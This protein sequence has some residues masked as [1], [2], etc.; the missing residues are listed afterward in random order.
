MKKLILF[1]LCFLACA[2]LVGANPQYTS[3][4]GS[5]YQFGVD[6]SPRGAWSSTIG[7]QIGGN[8]N[9]YPNIMINNSL[10]NML[11]PLAMNPLKST[12][13]RADEIYMFNSY[14]INVYDSNFV[15]VCSYALSAWNGTV[16]PVDVSDYNSYL[17][18][19]LSKTGADWNLNILNRSTSCFTL[20]KS[21]NV[22]DNANYTGSVLGGKNG[23]AYIY[24]VS[25]NVTKVNIKT[26]AETI[27]PF[28]SSGM[29]RCANP[30]YE[31]RSEAVSDDLNGDGYDDL[32]LIG[33]S[34]ASVY[35]IGILNT[36]TGS[37][38]TQITSSSSSFN[39]CTAF[40]AQIGTSS[41]YI[42]AQRIPASTQTDLRVYDFGGN[43]IYSDNDVADVPAAVGDFDLDGNNEL[44]FMDK[45]TGLQMHV[46]DNSFAEKY[47]LTNVI[48]SSSITPTNCPLA[49]Y[50][51]G[52]GY[53]EILSN[54][55]IQLVNSTL[56]LH[57]SSN[58][59]LISTIRGSPLNTPNDTLSIPSSWSGMNYAFPVAIQSSTFKDILL[60]GTNLQPSTAILSSTYGSVC[61]NGICETGETSVTCPED[62]APTT[63]GAAIISR[64]STNPCYT[65]TWLVNTTAQITAAATDQ[66][67]ANVNIYAYV[68]YGLCSANYSS[69][70]LVHD[71]E[72]TFNF[73]ANCTGQGTIRLQ[74]NTVNNPD[75]N[76]ITLPFT[77]S[78]FNGIVYG[79]ST[80]G[81][82][83]P[84]VAINIS[85]NLTGNPNNN[86]MV[87]GIIGLSNLTGLSGI[88]IWLIM[89]VILAMVIFIVGATSHIPTLI[90]AGF[91]FM[92][93]VLA[94]IIGSYLHILPVS[95][96][97][98]IALSLIIVIGLWIRGQATG[99]GG[100]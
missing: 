45:T 100:Q 23:N 68:D 40:P 66:D 96:V 50:A 55:G 77:V 15:N 81:I 70:N 83:Q 25:M 69:T 49:H 33:K 6:T 90:T 93:E 82:T 60:L 3:Y 76:T 43:L 71:A 37:W 51:S 4:A 42:I 53:M 87:N 84:L 16:S 91:A 13:S 38:T 19:Y 56:T 36:N 17:L 73:L 9:A 44:I 80:C 67:N 20:V 35:K 89:M 29:S 30:G 75:L 88:I 7:A 65:Q 59:Y 21:I 32:M 85:S 22:T 63:P 58:A 11:L 72:T 2:F 12:G 54:S 95:F 18:A 47:T 48:C 26:N 79:D 14:S 34:G 24:D 94:V 74:A 98:V 64:A 99:A 78:Q 5:G 27:Y 10:S 41:R 97:I 31:F 52:Q 62:C 1:V 57:G 8:G 86:G 28:W 61:G 92:V 39:Q 46:K